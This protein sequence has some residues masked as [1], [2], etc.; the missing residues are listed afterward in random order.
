MIISGDSNKD[1]SAT[2]FIWSTFLTLSVLRWLNCLRIGD[3]DGV[4]VR[5]ILSDCP[6]HLLFF[7]GGDGLFT[8]KRLSQNRGLDSFCDYSVVVVCTDIGVRVPVRV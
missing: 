2:S 4:V 7:D 8:D 6:S 1:V 5:R 3:Q